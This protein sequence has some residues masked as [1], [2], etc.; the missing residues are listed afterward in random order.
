MQGK[1]KPASYHICAQRTGQISVQSFSAPFQDGDT[2]NLLQ[3]AGNSLLVW[4]CKLKPV[5]QGTYQLNIHKNLCVLYFYIYI[6]IHNIVIL[7][8]KINLGW[9]KTLQKQ[10]PLRAPAITEQLSVLLRAGKTRYFNKSLK[11]FPC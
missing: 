5:K 4:K 8:D 2:K 9:S 3:T 10:L 1:R 11:G 7:Q 6:C